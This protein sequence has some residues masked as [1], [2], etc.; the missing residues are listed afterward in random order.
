MRS[1]VLSNPLEEVGVETIV[2]RELGMEGEAQDVFLFHGYGFPLVR[3]KYLDT[4]SDPDD[5]GC[6]DEDCAKRIGMSRG[7]R[8]RRDGKEGLKAEDLPSVSI[9]SNVDVQEVQR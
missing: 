8:E 6:A 9:S 5:A 4:L 7:V 1:L 3:G 2:L